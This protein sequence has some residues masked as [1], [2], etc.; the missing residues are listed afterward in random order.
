ME[1]QTISHYRVLSE[2]GRGGMGIVYKAEDIRLHRPVA[3]KFLSQE[4]TRDFDA[5]QRFIQEARA[6]SSLDHP[7]ICTIYDIDESADGRLFL[8]MAYY[9][10][11]PLNHRLLRGALDPVAA[12]DI[13][14]QVA[15]GLAKAHE[16]GI[17]HRDIKPAN[18]F[19]TQEGLVKILDFGVAKLVGQVGLTRTDAVLGTLAYMAPEQRHGREADARTDLWSLG[20]VLCEMLTGQLPFADV[21]AP[22]SPGSGKSETEKAIRL[23]HGAASSGLER[24]VL[25]AIQQDPRNRYQS[26]QEFIRDLEATSGALK[27]PTRPVRLNRPVTMQAALGALV[28]L[29][30]A[31]VGL[32]LWN[33]N[34]EPPAPRDASIPQAQPSAVTSQ[35]PR[36]SASSNSLAVLPFTNNSSN[37]EQEYFADG[38]TDELINQ[39]AKL[40]PLRVIAHTSAFTFKGSKESVKSIAEQLGV[41]HVLEGSVSRAGDAVRITAQLID[42]QDGFTRWSESYN[43]RLDDIFAIQDDIA[44]SVAAALRVTLGLKEKEGSVMLGGTADIRAY[45]LY[46][47]ARALLNSVGRGGADQQIVAN[48]LE[49]IQRAIDRDPKFALAWVLNSHA[50]DEAQNYFPED[51]GTHRARADE[52]AQR[53]YALE[54]NLPE[55][56]LELA[57]KAAARLE[58]TAAEAEFAEARALGLSDD[59]MNQYA[60]VLA[61]TGHIR[62]ARD[63]FL[64]SH[65]SDPLDSTL[66]LYLMVTY[67]ILGDTTAA[68]EFYDRGKAL[69]PNWTAGDFNA[70]V[71]LW[72][73]RGLDDARAKS[74][75]AKIPG[76]V[77]EAVNRLYGS[78]QDVLKELKRLYADA[79]FANPINHMAIA[80]AAAYFGDEELALRAL[81]SASE[82]M[83]LYAHKFW[84]PLFGKVRKLPAFKDFMRSHGF[85]DY[86]QRYSWPDQCRPIGTDFTCD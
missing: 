1:G 64:S 82:A 70:L 53:A 15:S 57:F 43:R 48:S 35:P 33:R 63:L 5:K 80:A 34:N 86:W 78:P 60:F 77:F 3:L 22:G 2:I 19:V 81:A 85:V 29:L 14:K 74:L 27:Q 32:Y 20:I 7:N 23:V 83:P 45:D 17:V 31:G 79:A 50:H 8:G 59:Q 52:A 10:G 41:E 65:A 68:L 71:V 16:A 44:R 75:A 18:L 47:S 69:F 38:I 66:F 21:P 37:P 26:T 84:Q 72:G 4:L 56:H 55:A 6:A 36:A 42:A 13:A 30:L 58:W 67:D 62:R 54:P 46:L 51:V 49:Q 9:E 61:N 39:L 76:P 40:K 24:V 11:E 25:R 28:A 12:I 73:R